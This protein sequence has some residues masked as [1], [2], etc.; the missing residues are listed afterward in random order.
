MS[1]ATGIFAASDAAPWQDGT[2]TT[3]AAART[4]SAGREVRGGSA[5]EPLEGGDGPDKLY[6]GS[7]NDTLWGNG[8]DDQLRGG[9]GDDEMHGGAGNDTLLGDG[10][11]RELLYGD[12]GDDKLFGR[13]ENDTLVGGQGRDLYFGGTGDD[14]YVF[15]SASESPAGKN[16]DIIKPEKPN[17]PTVAFEGAGKEGG[18]VID[19]RDFGDLSWGTSLYVKDVYR[20]THVYIDQNLDGRPEFEVAIYDDDRVTASDY[21][22]GDFLF[23]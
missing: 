15:S 14:T 22:A 23:V 3:A 5:S 10:G 2:T 9:I 7:G 18:D 17:H 13:E 4:V 21:T 6:G 12:D 16:R 8:G 19:L 11:G 1:T 20:H